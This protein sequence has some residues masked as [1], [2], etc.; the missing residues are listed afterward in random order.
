MFQRKFQEAQE[1]ANWTRLD[2]VFFENLNKTLM[3]FIA[4][5]VQKLFLYLSV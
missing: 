1:I 4:E 5:F 2:D 3:Q